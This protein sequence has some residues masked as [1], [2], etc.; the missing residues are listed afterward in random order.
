MT[1]NEFA[2]PCLIQVETASV[3]EAEVIDQKA[4]ILLEQIQPATLA[5]DNA[6][7]KASRIRNWVKQGITLLS[8]AFNWVNGHFAKA[9]HRFIKQPLNALR[10]RNRKTIIEPLF[11]LIAKVIGT[12]GK[13]KQLPVQHLDH[14][15]AGLA[16]ATLAVQIAMLANNIWGLPPRNVSEM[17]A[18]FQ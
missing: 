3:S 2:F 6:Y 17:A 1:C 18:A 16:L 4:P 8:P 12:T 10:L 13:Q 14:V 7:A 11:D 9:Y 15:R 5:A